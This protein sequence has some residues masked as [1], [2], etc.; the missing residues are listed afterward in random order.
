MLMHGRLTAVDFSQI[1]SHIQ[2]P[3]TLCRAL[4][5][6]C[7]AEL[8]QKRAESGARLRALR[9]QAEQERQARH[10]QVVDA[11]TVPGRRR[12]PQQRP[13]PASSG[14]GGSSA[15][16]RAHTQ[17]H[18]GSSKERLLKKLGLGGSGSGSRHAAA[19][20]RKTVTVIRPAQPPTAAGARHA[21]PIA[22]QQARPSPS[23]QRQPQPHGVLRSP[24]GS[25]HSPTGSLASAGRSPLPWQQQLQ[26]AR[27]GST[28]MRL[29]LQSAAG[30]A[31]A[32]QQLQAAGSAPA[33]QQLQA[34]GSSPLGQQRPQQQA[35]QPQKQQPQQ[36]RQ[37]QQTVHA[38]RTAE[39]GLK[40][41]LPM[42]GAV[43][44]PIGELCSNSNVLLSTLGGSERPQKQALPLHSP[45][46]Q[47]GSQAPAAAAGAAAAVQRKK[48]R[49]AKPQALEEVDLFAG[50]EDAP[51]QPRP[52]PQPTP[53][54]QLER[55]A[56]RSGAAG[57][58]GGS[59]GVQPPAKKLKKQGLTL[60]EVDLFDGL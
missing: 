40:P 34:A 13:G 55:S 3:L 7:Q 53:Q 32:R 38:L 31:P 60:V 16:H 18:A 49:P 52:A 43:K 50:V 51:V 36:Q 5:E 45:Q 59:R 30:S 22:P 25:L 12:R 37:Q 42:A 46:Q 35:Q 9:E 11:R 41:Q 57:K 26:A 6:Q 24:A 44:S 14:A 19:P 23:A 1:M 8:E 20:P 48:A 47:S 58:G 33:R 10:T 27:A 17:Q 4:Y 29:Q 15:S 54:L 2:P 28:P 56:E 39:A 21:W